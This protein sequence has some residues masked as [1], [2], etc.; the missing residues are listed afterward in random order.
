[1]VG[2]LGVRDG[3]E[4]SVNAVKI[5]LRTEQTDGGKCTEI[6]AG[7]ERCGAPVITMAR[8]DSSAVTGRDGLGQPVGQLEVS[9]LRRVGSDNVR[10]AMPPR[11]SRSTS[12]LVSLAQGAGTPVSGRSKRVES[13]TAEVVRSTKSIARSRSSVDSR[14]AMLL[15]RKCTIASAAPDTV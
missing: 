11:C 12:M 14:C 15:A 1:M 2:C 5:S 9:A 8:T 4:T 3:D 13:T 7:A 10:T 6:T